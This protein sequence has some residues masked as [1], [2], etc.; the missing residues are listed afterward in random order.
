[1]DSDGYNINDVQLKFYDCVDMNFVYK[2][3]I[4]KIYLNM[5]FKD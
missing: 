4:V 5:L 2:I 1:M 3:D